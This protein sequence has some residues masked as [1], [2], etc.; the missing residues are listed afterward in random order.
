MQRSGKPVA[1]PIPLRK[2]APFQPSDRLR[3]GFAVE[4]DELVSVDPK[5]KI[6]REKL[7][8]EQ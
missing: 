7:T 5:G 2:S 8:D 1:R 3:V 4:G 6:T